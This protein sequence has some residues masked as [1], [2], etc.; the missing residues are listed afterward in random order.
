[1][2]KDHVDNK[3]EAVKDNSVDERKSSDAIKDIKKEMD[4]FEEKIKSGEAP[5]GDS[6]RS[7][8]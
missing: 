6:T 2:D 8:E 7:E 5:A 1:M 3:K 4:T